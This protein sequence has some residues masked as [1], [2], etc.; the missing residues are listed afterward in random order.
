[1]PKYCN[2]ESW[3]SHWHER[4][5]HGKGFAN[6]YSGGESGSDGAIAGVV[7]QGDHLRGPLRRARNPT[8]TNTYNNG[9][10]S[11]RTTFKNTQCGT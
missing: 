2:D 10:M 8:L 4:S 11:G 5:F 6:S 9:D 7:R 1:M 3:C